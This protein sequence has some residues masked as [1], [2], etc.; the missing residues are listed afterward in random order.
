MRDLLFPF[1]TLMCASLMNVDSFAQTG[2]NAKLDN[3]EKQYELAK[4][5]ET[6]AGVERSLETAI[7]LYEQAAHQG[8]SQSMLRLG[9]LYYNGEVLGGTIKA[10][11]ELAWLWFTFAAAHGQLQATGD[12]EVIAKDLHPSILRDLKM[13]AAETLLEGNEV[14]ASV[15]KSVELYRSLAEDGSAKAAEILGALYMEGKLVPRQPGLA[16]A[17]YEKA[18]VAGSFRAMYGLAKIA[19]SESP[20][21]LPKALEL[22]RKAARKG[23]ARSMYRLGEMYTGGLGVTRDLV[24]AHAWFTA[25][26]YFKLDE[27]TAAARRLE[28]ELSR[29]QIE[30][31][32]I[33]T[34]KLI[35]SVEL[36]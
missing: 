28:A 16:S 20:P 31:A 33:E 3:P 14:P 29:A 7:D 11:N 19:E 25:A 27:G 17:W 5:Y 34:H 22:Y 10:D 18:A 24:L 26:G 13:H 35:A 15:D 36:P 32:Q 4:K 12:A 30:K 9:I 23:D 1:M 8:H 6:G 2:E 21:N